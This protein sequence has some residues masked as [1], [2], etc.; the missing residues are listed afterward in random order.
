MLIK[1]PYHSGGGGKFYPYNID[2]SMLTDGGGDYLLQ[3]FAAGDRTKWTY[4]HWFKVVDYPTN[5]NTIFS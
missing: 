4:S 1:R 3:T 5:Q 2:N